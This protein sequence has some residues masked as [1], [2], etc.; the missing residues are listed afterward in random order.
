MTSEER[1]ASGAG[2]YEAV[3]GLEVHAQLRT[4]TK[5]FCG[6]ATRFGD[7]PN[8]N[9]CPVC[10]GMPGALPVLNARVVEFAVRAALAT[11]CRVNRR[12]VFARKNYFY[13]D[14]PKGYQISQYEE[15]LAEHG[16]LLVDE[17]AGPVRVRLLRIH[18]EEDAGKLL[19]EGLHDSQTMSYVDYNRAGVPLIEIVSQPDLREPAQAYHYL[20]G[21]RSILL[22]LGVCDG[23]MEEGSLRCDANV[24]IRPRGSGELGTKIEIKNL[25]SFRNVQ[26]AL[27]YEIRRQSRELENGGS[28]VQETR[29]WDAD[30][31][32]T[33]PMRSKEEAMDYRYFPEPDL[34]PLVLDE[35]WI[36]EMRRSIPELPAAKAA[37]YERDWGLP[38][39]DAQ[40]LAAEPVTA[41]WIEEA[42]ALSGNPRVTANW[43]ITEL[44]G[45]LNAAKKDLSGSPVTP[46]MLASL[47]KLIDAGTISG[48]IAKT[49]FEE[50]FETGAPP[51]SIVEKKGLV[52][53]VDEGVLAALVDEVIAAHPDQAADYRGGKKA[54]LG[55]FVGQ[56]M[57][58]SG[59]KAN[60]KL[61]NR[62]LAEKLR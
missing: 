23:N 13:P 11:G 15:P 43:L 38:A 60:P 8:T 52:Q 53:I 12:S 59:G 17:G 48:K 32:R 50:M 14:L 35:A 25:N 39:Q 18:I 56:V 28:V 16:E 44:T 24:S 27:E 5:I 26:R 41:S 47:V 42:V 54:A 57:K 10:L 30:E 33:D 3:I 45:R 7:P 40:L 2:K 36:E 19:H 20:T 6:C 31:G 9:T 22:H 46:A 4:A 29:L 49:V 34:P 37:R 51:E 58:A 21:L 62:L 1:R 55:W 61:V